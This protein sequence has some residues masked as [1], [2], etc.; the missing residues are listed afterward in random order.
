MQKQTICSLLLSAAAL[1]PVFA[2]QKPPIIDMHMHTRTG[3]IPR[4]ASGEIVPR[5]CLPHSWCESA[6]TVAGSAEEVRTLTLEAMRRNNIVLGFL[7]GKVD[8]VYEWTDDTPNLFI[9]A[10]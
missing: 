10:P 6:P 7:S 2:Q 8:Q 1:A 4:T 5:M 9:G 3:P